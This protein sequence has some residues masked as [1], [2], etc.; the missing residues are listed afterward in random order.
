MFGGVNRLNPLRGSL[1]LVWFP[2]VFHPRRLMFGPFGA[3]LGCVVKAVYQGVASEKQ[4]ALTG[5]V[6]SEDCRLIPETRQHTLPASKEQ[7]SE[8]SEHTRTS[9][10]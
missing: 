2:W 7:G 1:F 9:R 4:N 10:R 6:S 8:Q 5:A 3:A